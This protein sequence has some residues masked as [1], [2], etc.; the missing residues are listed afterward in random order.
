MDVAQL[1]Q[2]AGDALL[3]PQLLSDIQA[4]LVELARLDVVALLVV[5][6]AQLAQ[7]VGDALFV[8]QLLENIQVLLVE[9][10]R[11]GVVAL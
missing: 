6:V 8:P 2:G 3:V 7:G 10:G 9:L 1:V 11:L 4:P 5:D